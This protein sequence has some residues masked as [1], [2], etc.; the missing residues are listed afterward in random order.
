MP[1]LPVPFE[2]V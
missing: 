2:L 1:L